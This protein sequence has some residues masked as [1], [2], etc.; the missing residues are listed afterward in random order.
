[1]TGLLW[2]GVV[3]TLQ[4]GPPCGG[5]LVQGTPVPVTQPK[6]QVDLKYIKDTVGTCTT[7]VSVDS[8][9]YVF[10]LSYGQ[11]ATAVPAYSVVYSN[12]ILVYVY[13]DGTVWSDSQ[14]TPP[15]VVSPTNLRIP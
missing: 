6:S 15:P 13:S 1:M 14:A 12:R 3:L 2:L 8:G 5:W 9:N 4:W 7:T 10:A 11:Q